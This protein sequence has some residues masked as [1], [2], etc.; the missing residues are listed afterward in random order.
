MAVSYAIYIA[1]F[2]NF[3]MKPKPSMSAGDKMFG[4]HNSQQNK[5]YNT[6]EH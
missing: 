4:Q 3:P 5:F 6:L 2:N 1:Y